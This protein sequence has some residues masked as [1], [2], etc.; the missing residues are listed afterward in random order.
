[1]LIRVKWFVAAVVVIALQVKTC[2]AEIYVFG[3]SLSETGNFHAITGGEQPPSPLYFDGRL[4]NGKAWVEYFARAVREPVPTPSILGGSNFAFNGARAAG[5]SPYGTPD[6]A[7]QVSSYLSASGGVANP[8]DIFIVW[9]GANDIFFGPSFGE[10]DFIPNAI[11]GIRSS[12]ETL[13]D[14][15]ARDIVVLDLPPLGETPFFN[16]IPVVSAQ[17]NAASFEF[18]FELSSLVRSLRL[19]LPHVRIADAKISR[20][21]ESVARVPRLFGLKNVTDSATRFDPVTGIVFETIPGVDASR[22]LFWDSV[23]PTTKGHKII[24]AYVFID[25]KLHCLHR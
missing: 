11:D 17:L 24:A 20:L 18:N 2:C 21:F 8:D 12:I 14:A 15:G 4:S 5:L 9:A 19:E 16:T 22:Y 6:L 7:A 10:S 23:H 25:Y 1:M 3:D 13:Y